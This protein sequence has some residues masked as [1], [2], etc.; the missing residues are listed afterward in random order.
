MKAIKH[1]D[2]KH[3]SGGIYDRIGSIVDPDFSRPGVGDKIEN[4]V[5]PIFTWP[6]ESLPAFIQGIFGL[7]GIKF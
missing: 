5:H 7:L 6:K 2:L 3:V 1:E 4:A